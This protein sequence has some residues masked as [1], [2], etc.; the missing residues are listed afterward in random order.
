MFEENTMW[1]VALYAE[2]L[3][4]CDSEL[5]ELTSRTALKQNVTFAN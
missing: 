3:W 4:D 2:M 5:S 1:P